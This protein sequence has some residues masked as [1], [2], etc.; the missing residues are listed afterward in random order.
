MRPQQQKTRL[1]RKLTAACALA[2]VFAMALA[3]PCAMGQ[4]QQGAAPPVYRFDVPLP[5]TGKTVT[6][7]LGQTLGKLSPAPQRPIFVLEFRP[8][9]GTAGEGSSFGDA[10]DLARFLSGDQMSGVRTVAWVSRTLK[11]HAVLPVL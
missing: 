1:S 7:R 11:G 8:A 6:R 5:I 2:G 4:E 3:A 10:L 9:E